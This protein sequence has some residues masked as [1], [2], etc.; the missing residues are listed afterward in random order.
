ML[1]QLGRDQDAHEVRAVFLRRNPGNE[2][3][4]LQF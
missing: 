1:R 4:L 2:S 3:V